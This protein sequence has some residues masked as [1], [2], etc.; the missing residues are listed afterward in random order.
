MGMKEL[1]RR[2]AAAAAAAVLA[3]SMV[4][5]GCGDKKG[6]ADVSES[7]KATVQ[8][9]A[10]AAASPSAKQTQYPLTIKDSTGTDITFE[11]APERIVTLAPSE[12]ESVYAAG[13]GAKIVAVDKWSDYPEDAK[14]KPR[15]GDMTTNAEAVLASTPDIVFAS[16]SS[17]KKAVEALRKLNVKVFASDPTTIEQAIARVELFGQIL[18]TQE[19]AKK[20]VDEMRAD[21][22]KV[23]D[24]VKNAPKKRVY[25][26][27]NPGW[28]VG[29]GE[30]MN[31]IVGLAGGINI[32]ATKKGWY[33]IDPE[34][35][36][37]SNPEVIVYTKDEAG[38]GSILDEMNKRPGWEAIDAM[39]NKKT[40]AV[41][42]N[43]VSRVGPRVTK[44]LVE[45]AKAIH[46]DL[47]R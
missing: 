10:A 39:K 5:A 15:I 22:K 21:V 19:Q 7:P 6:A 41:E 13:G 17:N 14:S 12:T 27:F 30:Y 26:E 16:G 4:L 11:K 35:I 1:W 2:R 32:A 47:V 46:P 24:A 29:D 42:S 25:L 31:E 33:K 20:A 28:T 23:T 36:I 45:V 38:M 9:S 37:K 3:L 43:L 34:D 44:G 8:P 40:Y 18:N